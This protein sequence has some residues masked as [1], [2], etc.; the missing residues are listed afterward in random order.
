MENTKT[1]GRAVTK[2]KKAGAVWPSPRPIA[3][4][5]KL[6]RDGEIGP[7]DYNRDPIHQWS[8]ELRLATIRA[9][10]AR[11]LANVRIQ[12]GSQIGGKGHRDPLRRPR[13][14]DHGQNRSRQRASLRRGAARRLHGRFYCG[15]LQISEVRRLSP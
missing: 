9:G 11:L 15:H 14:R 8:E 3:H 1:F 5:Q 4:A 10:Q 12:Y 6:D 13:K 2:V 7:Y